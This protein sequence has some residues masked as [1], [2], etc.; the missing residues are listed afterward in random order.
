[1]DG[2]DKGK[3]V[4][5]KYLQS[6]DKLSIRN[7]RSGLSKIDEV[8]RVRTTMCSTKKTQN[9]VLHD[10][11]NWKQLDAGKL[12]KVLVS[13]H[14]LQDDEIFK[15]LREIMDALCAI[16]SEKRQSQNVKTI[17]PV[18]HLFAYVLERFT[19]KNFRDRAPILE[20][21]IRDGFHNNKMHK[22]LIACVDHYMRWIEDKDAVK[23]NPRDIKVFLNSMS[24]FN[25]I[26]WIINESR[27]QD[28]SA[29][30]TV[31]EF[32]GAVLDLMKRVNNLMQV[33]EPVQIKVIR[34]KTLNH[35]PSVMDHLLTIFTPPEVGV[36]AASFLDVVP[37]AGLT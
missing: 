14:S 35:F 30:K 13:A 6:K 9:G 15:F 25:Y 23:S 22:V 5:P 19:N 34:G 28:A 33:E 29:D 31:V 27:Q 7:Y 17:L 12:E 4:V 26:I 3:M 2:M 8:F 1:M 37:V 21:Y 10:L 11:I 20:A 32:K 16:F 24:A 18:F 36:I